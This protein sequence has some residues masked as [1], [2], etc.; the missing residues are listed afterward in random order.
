MITGRRKRHRIGAYVFSG[1]KS[2]LSAPVALGAG[3]G[4]SL[5]SVR[6]VSAF[7]S[8]D[9]KT[10]RRRS[11][12]GTNLSSAS[13]ILFSAMADPKESGWGRNRRKWM[14]LS[15]DSASKLIRVSPLYDVTIG[16]MDP[17]ARKGEG[18]YHV[19]MASEFS[20]TQ[21]VWHRY[22]RDRKKVKDRRLI[23]MQLNSNK[24]Y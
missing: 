24:S 7:H 12:G 6:H 5:I 23:A 17:I 16:F 19:M 21:R 1:T 13:W 9:S 20:T 22:V 11:E 3:W 15:W 4:K 10:M 14:P 18:Q 2:I 8:I